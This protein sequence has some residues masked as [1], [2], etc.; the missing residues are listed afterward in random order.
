[1][2][3]IFHGNQSLFK[4]ILSAVQNT[5]FML[6]FKNV[7]VGIKKYPLISVDYVDSVDVAVFKFVLSIMPKC[8]PSFSS[9]LVQAAKSSAQ[10]NMQLTKQ[11]D[12]LLTLCQIY[13]TVES[14]QH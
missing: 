9:I 8:V 7:G 2:L 14:F 5:K 13:N 12:L 10:K 1:M 3:T 6:L 4:R 11:Y